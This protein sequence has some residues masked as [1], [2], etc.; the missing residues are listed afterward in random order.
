MKR[1]RGLMQVPVIPVCN[2]VQQRLA[3]VIQI[4]ER[5]PGGGEGRTAAAEEDDEE[6]DPASS[7]NRISVCA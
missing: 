6:E 1:F 2:L 4:G 5:L 7:R 3:V